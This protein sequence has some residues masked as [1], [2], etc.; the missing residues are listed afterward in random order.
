MIIIRY[1]G[2]LGNQMFQHALS[3]VLRDK[4]PDMAVKA[5][6]QHYRLYKVH[7]GFEIDKCFME[8]IN[9]ANAKE[10]RKKSD[11]FACGMKL[12]FLS[13][14]IVNYIEREYRRAASG[15]KNIIR[16]EVFNS[17]EKGLFD[18]LSKDNDYYIE[19][20]WQNWKYFIGKEPLLQQK[21]KFKRNLTA[22]QDIIWK[23]EMMESNSVSIHVRRGDFVNSKSHDICNMA[24]YK[25]AI[26]Y[27]KEKIDNPQFF[28]F[29]DDI[30]Y[31][32]KYLGNEMKYVLHGK[33]D[34]DLDMQLMSMCKHNIIP[35]SSFS[36]WAAVL[37][38]NKQKIVIFPRYFFTKGE[39]WFEFKA[40]EEWVCI[41]N[42]KC[43]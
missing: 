37:N 43:R 41:D 34:S 15:E 38:G 24:Y 26:A 1:S 6:A 19:G 14:S 23:K 5:D 30:E 27:M 28:V 40:P 25:K 32:Q 8:K 9:Y 18:G 20:E 39:E 33:E 11:R 3:I 17:Y 2:G 36:F 12:N 4:Y 35:N 21:F 22:E 42:R 10:I 16:Q 7:N 29:S 13:P 31:A